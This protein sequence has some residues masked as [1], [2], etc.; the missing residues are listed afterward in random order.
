MERRSFTKVMGLSAFAI[1]TTGFSL[2]KKADGTISTDCASSRDMLGP[3]YRDGA[4]VRRN[5]RYEGNDQEIPLKVKGQVFGSECN[6]PLTDILVDIWHCDHR[7]K[8][9]M[10][11]QEYRCRCQFKTD[12]EG[13][14]W[15]ETFVPPPYQG[16][17]KHIHYLIHDSESHQELVTQLYFK[18]DRK[19]KKGNWVKYPWDNRR[20]LEVYENEEGIAEVTLDLYLQPKV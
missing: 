8:Y 17:P 1:S 15:F 10:K 16:R 14:Y 18:G 19:I 2:I 4:P 3:F 11:S 7:R 9:D 20:I 12:K 13:R 6:N 5:I